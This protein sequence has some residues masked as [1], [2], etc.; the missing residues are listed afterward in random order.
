MT[1]VEPRKGVKGSRE[2]DPR[3][4]R[5][6]VADAHPGRLVALL[7]VPLCLASGLPVGYVDSMVI[8][9]QLSGPNHPTSGLLMARMSIVPSQETTAVSCWGTSSYWGGRLT[10]FSV[11]AVFPPT[12]LVQ[13]R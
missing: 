12:S 9:G 4:P 5:L 1:L 7:P 6:G 8:R 13:R 2:Q 11:G 3:C 10:T